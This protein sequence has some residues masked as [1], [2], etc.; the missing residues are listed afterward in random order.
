MTKADKNGYARVNHLVKPVLQSRSFSRVNAGKQAQQ[1]KDELRPI[2][3]EVI[4]NLQLKLSIYALDDS[5]NPV[6]HYHFESLDNDSSFENPAI[7]LVNPVEENPLNQIIMEKLLFLKST[8]HGTF[9]NTENIKQRLIL[10]SVN[11][12]IAPN[13]T[14]VSLSGEID[15]EVLDAFEVILGGVY[16][17]HW[18]YKDFVNYVKRYELGADV[19][20]LSL[21][22][23]VYNEEKAT[24]GDLGREFIE[25]TDLGMKKA[26]SCSRD[27][28]FLK[29]LTKEYRRSKGQEQQNLEYAGLE[30]ARGP[31]KMLNISYPQ[32]RTWWEQNY[33][34]STGVKIFS[35]GPISVN[36][37]NALA[38]DYIPSLKTK[39]LNRESLP[40]SNFSLHN[41][42]IDQPVSIHRKYP[43]N[44]YS[45]GSTYGLTFK[46]PESEKFKSLDLEILSFILFNTPNSPFFTTFLASQTPI[47]TGFCPNV[48][49][50]SQSNTFTIGFQN[51]TTSVDLDSPVY[52]TWFDKSQLEDVDFSQG[53]VV[54]L[55][56]QVLQELVLQTL[57]RCLSSEKTPH[58][59]DYWILQST[60]DYI[61]SSAF[62]KPDNY[63]SHL[64]QNLLSVSDLGQQIGDEAWREKFSIF[65]DL[66]VM[67]DIVLDN[68]FSDYDLPLD[69]EREGYWD[70]I[71]EQTF[72]E[73]DSFVEVFLEI[74]YSQSA[75]GHA[76]LL[77]FDEYGVLI[78]NEVESMEKRKEKQRKIRE[79]EILNAKMN[80]GR[81]PKIQKIDKDSILTMK[82][83]HQAELEQLGFVNPLDY[84]RFEINHL[85]SK[86]QG[87]QNKKGLQNEYQGQLDQIEEISSSLEEIYNIY[88][89]DHSNLESKKHQALQNVHNL[90]QK[91]TNSEVQQI[92]KD[93]I[94][95][96]QYNSQLVDLG[97]LPKSNLFT[98]KEDLIA[99]RDKLVERLEL[100]N[101][102]QNNLN[103][104][105]KEVELSQKGL[106]YFK[107][108]IDF[109]DLATEAPELL[110]YLYLMEKLFTRIGTISL[111]PDLF[112]TKISQSV[113]D[114]EFKILTPNSSSDSDLNLKG[115]LRIG[116]LESNLAAGIE[117]LSSFLSEPNFRDY[118]N[119]STQIRIISSELTKEL[120]TDA[121]TMVQQ[122]ALKGNSANIDL[123]N[124][125]DN[126]IL[127]VF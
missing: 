38:R 55:K 37:I 49:Y 122:R 56:P 125:V 17:G 81:K 71:L 77:S 117:I 29:E 2:S 69:M 4:D 73:N 99:K 7:S 51:L 78:E 115:V 6:L 36:K 86:V 118:E 40:Q 25:L 112:Q 19:E 88:D 26:F 106:V 52:S 28:S 101:K 48:G 54:E 123:W 31:H 90:F 23:E 33:S 121:E 5:P 10:D 21:S 35:Y 98:I 59:F 43:A 107:S 65:Q 41:A 66:Q 111:K 93:E 80:K 62:I 120:I 84:Q 82:S 110:P 79:Q 95:V 61:S 116:C 67:R 87:T 114:L 105:F 64:L 70:H 63:G 13:S 44:P 45:A 58:N 83:V 12:E 124:D 100:Q 68:S 113:T 42:I 102:T 126:V 53:S 18:D 1:G 34:G 46:I 72:F 109:S 96:K 16:E 24:L 76:N 94:W 50:N 92:L 15:R 60:L 14:L 89:L 127:F 22:G 85:Q 20:G 8:K 75:E 11:S 103:I 57:E 32:I 91:L 97:K 104:T 30:P 108:E 3:S 74:D 9:L 39:C 47:A 119:I 27:P